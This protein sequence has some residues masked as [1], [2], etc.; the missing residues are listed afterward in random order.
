MRGDGGVGLRR[1]ARPA[2][3][4][5]WGG[6]YDLPALRLWRR[7][8]LPHVGGLQS[9]TEAAAAGPASEEA[10]QALGGDV[11]K[12]DGLAPEAG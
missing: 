11:A 10:L 7:S 2:E 5:R 4:E 6:L 3:L 1:R 12:G 8:A 9:Q